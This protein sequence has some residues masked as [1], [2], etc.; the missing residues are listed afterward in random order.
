MRIMI[1]RCILQAV[2]DSIKMYWAENGRSQR[3]LYSFH[4]IPL[5]Y[6]TKG[7]PYRAYCQQSAQLISD[8]L[9]LTED[10]Y[11]ICFQSRFGPQEWLQPYT[12][13]TLE[14]WAKDG[15]RSVDTIC[16]GFAVDCLET[17]EEM[18]ELNKEIYLQAGGEAYQ[19][20]PCLNDSEGQVRLMT[21]LV[22]E[23]TRGWG[24]NNQQ[25]T[26]NLKLK[27]EDD[28][29]KTIKPEP[30]PVEGGMQG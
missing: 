28:G 25:L 29:R 23:N 22:K 11:Q 21:A 12:D 5:S 6:E 30:E 15:P 9:G 16:P 24:E 27:N 13:K 2:A 1:T 4:G 14:A 3:L 19:Y 18:G 7:D 8:Q 10:E 20:I 26:E 17:L